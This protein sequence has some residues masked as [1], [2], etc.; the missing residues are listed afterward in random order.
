MYINIVIKNTVR[1]HIN[2]ISVYLKYNQSLLVVVDNFY[3]VDRTDTAVSA[4]FSFSPH[5]NPVKRYL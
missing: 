2:L 4:L 3:W 5:S 1:V